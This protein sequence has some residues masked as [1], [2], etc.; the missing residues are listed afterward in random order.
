MINCWQEIGIAGDQSCPVLKTV[1]HCYNCNVYSEAGQ[2]LFERAA[3]A[4]YLEDW[5]GR[6]AQPPSRRETEKDA[7]MVAVFRLGNEILGLPA[8]ILRVVVPPNSV[9]HIPHRSDSIFRGL[10]NIKGKLLLCVALEEL[11]HLH[12]Q[13]SGVGDRPKDQGQRGKEQK[14]AKPQMVV[15]EKKDSTWAFTVDEFYGVEKFLTTEQTNLP[16][17]SSQ[18]LDSFTQHILPWRNHNVSYLDAQQVFESLR[19]H[20]L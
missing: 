6:L 2:A 18:T 13:S 15:M 11:L 16:S 17:L 3:P 9:H 8:K 7:V 10:V 19:R 12:G 20:I 1:T 4:G 14:E 5:L